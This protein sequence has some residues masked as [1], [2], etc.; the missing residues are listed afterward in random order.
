[1]SASSHFMIPMSVAASRPRPKA[2]ALTPRPLNAAEWEA[3]DA[4]RRQA[5]L[6]ALLGI[7]VVGLGLVVMLYEGEDIGVIL[8]AFLAHA[9]W[10]AARATTAA[11]RRQ[12]ISTRLGTLVVHSRA[13]LVPVPARI[14]GRR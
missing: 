13:R 6:L 3:L 2:A 10:M 8:S 4:S 5:S 1:M 11:M 7:Y 14:Y 9:I 12:T